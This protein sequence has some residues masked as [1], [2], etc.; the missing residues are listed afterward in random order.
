VIV[1]GRR[2]HVVSFELGASARN[3]GVQFATVDD[4]TGR[5]S[6]DDVR[7]VIDAEADHQPHV[8]LVAIENSHMPSGGMVWSPEEISALAAVTSGL[9]LHVDGARLLNAAV[10]LGVAPRELVTHAS[11]VM[12]CLSK[13][14]GAPVG[15][16][17][18]GSQ[19]LMERGRIERKRLGGTM[20]QAGF[21]AAAGLV[22]VETMIERLADDHRR[23]R[24][25]ADAFAA[26]F[27]ESQYDPTTCQTNIVAF[28]HP[29][30]REI[31]AMLDNR[32]VAGGTIAP[33]RARFVTHLGVDDVD[34][35]Y[36]IETLR[37]FR[38]SSERVAG[39]RAVA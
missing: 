19:D 32:G 1:A 38:L 7:D 10:A 33:R 20:R 13:G 34:V 15:S 25:L 3:S 11:T 8:A 26:A 12:V 14:L 23:A 37:N 27:P 29:R 24:R 2:Q 30:A 5:L 4:T 18:V 6:L 9:P 39:P 16:L 28:D 22:A 17:L 31:V 21:L 35:D 36:V